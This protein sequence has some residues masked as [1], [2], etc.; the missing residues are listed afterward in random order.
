MRRL[1]LLLCM[2]FGFLGAK[3]QEGLSHSLGGFVQ[4]GYVMPTNDFV[5]GE[6]ASAKPIDRFAALSLRYTVLTSGEKPWH[7][8]FKYPS[9]GLGLYY[10][11][12]NVPVSWAIR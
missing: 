7:Q 1:A 12:F 3:A 5:R 11:G 8:L 6:N 10:A 9:Y 4:G 2:V